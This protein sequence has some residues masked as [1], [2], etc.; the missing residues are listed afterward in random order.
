MSEL[1]GGGIFEINLPECISLLIEPVDRAED[2][3]VVGDGAVLAAQHDVAGVGPRR[4]APH[5]RVLLAD[6]AQ[7]DAVFGVE[8]AGLVGPADHEVLPLRK[9]G[10]SA[11]VEAQR[12]VLAHLLA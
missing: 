12:P 10:H 9:E 2:E 8:D 6:G 5:P 11:R 7:L 1:S 3:L 4:A